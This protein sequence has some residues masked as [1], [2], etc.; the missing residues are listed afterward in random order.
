[1]YCSSDIT[2]SSLCVQTV[3]VLACVL[4]HR[5]P[6]PATPRSLQT[7][8]KKLA[9]LP[10]ISCL[11]GAESDDP[12]DSELSRTGDRWVQCKGCRAWMHAEC[13]TSVLCVQC[14][15]SLA[16]DKVPGHSRA[17]LIVCPDAILR[18]WLD[19]VTRHV[20]EGCLKVFHY[21][22]H[23]TATGTNSIDS[24]PLGSC[25]Q[26]YSSSC[27]SSYPATLSALTQKRGHQ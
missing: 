9:Q 26:T 4:H 11:C 6:R 24:T 27:N 21:K 2:G 10:R 12:N 25:M 15:H 22:G 13:M 19:E 7:R 14:L 23:T 5:C 3:E 16:A 18:Q 8:M 17:T 1:M 20:D